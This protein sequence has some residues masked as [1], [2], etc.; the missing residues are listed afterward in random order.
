VEGFPAT[1]SVRGPAIEFF[2]PGDASIPTLPIELP[3]IRIGVPAVRYGVT[4][5]AFWDGPN[6]FAYQATSP[7]PPNVH[8]DTGTTI[9]IIGDAIANALKLPP[10]GSFDCLERPRAGYVIGGIH[11]TGVG[12]DYVVRNVSV[13]WNP[14][15]Q[16]GFLSA[17]VGSNLFDQV[18]IVFDGANDRLWVG[19]PTGSP[20]DW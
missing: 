9:T 5:I 11:F 20:I 4:A 12:A 1:E 3:L 17:T 6:S 8:Y 18:P 2:V 16:P 7:T 19:E 10:A 14:A 15:A 13:C